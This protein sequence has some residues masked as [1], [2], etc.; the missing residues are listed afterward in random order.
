MK[1]YV[2][3]HGDQSSLEIVG[4]FTTRAG[5]E[6]CASFWQGMR[7]VVEWDADS[8]AAPAEIGFQLW[9]AAMKRDGKTWNVFAADPSWADESCWPPPN[10]YQFDG[11]TWNH[12]PSKYGGPALI[13]RRQQLITSGEWPE[14]LP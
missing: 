9:W 4:I 6:A 13:K 3:E 14:A 12:S 11:G 7:R 2:V 8:Y 1:I 5:A 10:W